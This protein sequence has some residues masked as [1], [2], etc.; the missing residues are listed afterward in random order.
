MSGDIIIRIAQQSDVCF[1]QNIITEIED[2][3]K[4]PAT[5]ICK[6]TAAFLT[7]KIT[8]GLSVIAVT[9]QGDWVGFCYIQEW[10]QARFVSSCALVIAPAFRN[11]G[12]AGA[13]KARIAELAKDKYPTA[14]LF[15]LTTS[16]AVM[17]INSQLGYEAVTYS[18]ITGDSGFWDSCQ[19]C[20]NYDI[21]Q[22][23][24]RKRCLCTAMLCRKEVS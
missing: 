7:Q 22:R 17:K 10:D 11:H 5:G 13:I 24:E 14:S 19:G 6:R 3:A 12:I 21:L 15:G 4:D 20:V 18:E 1:V 9:Q 23:N 2:A 8:A 16:S